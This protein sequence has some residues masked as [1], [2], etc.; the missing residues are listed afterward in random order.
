MCCE[1][2][3]GELQALPRFEVLHDSASA[4]HFVLTQ[5]TLYEMASTRLGCTESPCKPLA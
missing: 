1:M 3:D 2:Y 5:L 4:D